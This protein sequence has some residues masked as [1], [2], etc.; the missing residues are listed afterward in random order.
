MNWTASH[1]ADR[2]ELHGGV[3]NY[4]LLQAKAVGQRSYIS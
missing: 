1:L 3:Q 4:K 2:K